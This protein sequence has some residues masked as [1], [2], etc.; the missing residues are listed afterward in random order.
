MSFVNVLENHVWLESDIRSRAL[1]LR[2]EQ[3]RDIDAVSARV[4]SGILLGPQSIS[5]SDRD[6]FMAYQA[7]GMEVER[8]VAAGITANNALRGAIE[9]EAARARLAQDAAPAPA[10]D[11]EP[12]ALQAYA[13][14]LEQRAAATAVMNAAK[15]AAVECAA[16]RDAVFNPVAEPAEVSA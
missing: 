11:A 3:F 9:I 14:D 2:D 13:L 12:D 7:S 15:P 8:M 16:L 6:K 5:S 4:A 10:E 1:A